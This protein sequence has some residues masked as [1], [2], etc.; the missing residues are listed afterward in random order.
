MP[1]RLLPAT[2]E[3]QE[4]F[5][6]DF[7]IWLELQKGPMLVKWT[8][9]RKFVESAGNLCAKSAL[10]LMCK[11]EL[12]PKGICN[13][14]T[15]GKNTDY[16]HRNGEPFRLSVEFETRA[17]QPEPAPAQANLAAI[18]PEPA[19]AQANLAAI[20]PEPAP[21]QADLTAIMRFAASYSLDTRLGTA[22]FD[23][24]D[25]NV[26]LDMKKLGL[27]VMACAPEKHNRFC[28][29]A[30]RVNETLV[31]T[32]DQLSLIR[33]CAN[34]FYTKGDER[35]FEI[36]RRPQD[37]MRTLALQAARMPPC[38]P[39][40]GKT[41]LKDAPYTQVLRSILSKIIGVEIGSLFCHVQA[42]LRPS[43]QPLRSS[44]EYA[45]DSEQV[46]TA[47]EELEF[48]VGG[49]CVPRPP[50]LV[51]RCDGPALELP[52]VGITGSSGRPHHQLATVV[53][54]P[55]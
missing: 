36:S 10:D 41:L 17:V 51:F 54:A 34:Q 31:L 40:W 1:K 8:T 32:D 29:E 15:R 13:S 35:P 3:A 16:V 12:V 19:P 9:L 21:T 50:P 23:L 14:E 42:G 6:M 4:A 43:N 52:A 46:G 27:A 26:V 53:Q 25:G 11:H 39:A 22:C 24:C 20:Q 44:Q 55:H 48:L 7:A 33:D 18:Q 45:E 47:V 28:H 49:G 5:V 2:T 38:E 30:H 37:I